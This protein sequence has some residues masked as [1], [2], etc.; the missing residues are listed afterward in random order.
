[1]YLGDA[2]GNARMSSYKMAVTFVRCEK[3]TTQVSL[4][5]LAKFSNIEANDNL[6]SGFPV[7]LGLR[8]DKWRNFQRHSKRI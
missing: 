3:K 4:R 7:A 6:F 1:M 8:T 5:V 2:L